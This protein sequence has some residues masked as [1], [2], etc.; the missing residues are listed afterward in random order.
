ME[1][2]DKHIQM[3]F[4]SLANTNKNYILDFFFQES[5]QHYTEKYDMML[6]GLDESERQEEIHY[7]LTYKNQKKKLHMKGEIK[8]EKYQG[9]SQAHS[10]T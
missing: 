2:I 4:W 9:R 3:Q 8:K 6:I 1:I 7:R 5:A 10:A